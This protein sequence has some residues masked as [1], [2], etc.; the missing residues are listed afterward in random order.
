MGAGLLLSLADRIGHDR[1]T[2]AQRLRRAGR[3]VSGGLVLD[4][5]IQLGAEQHHEA[6]DPGPRHEADGSA[7]RTAGFVEPTEVRDV[8]GEQE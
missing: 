4:F 5:R 1:P 6:G 8:G 2:T 3:R 7:E